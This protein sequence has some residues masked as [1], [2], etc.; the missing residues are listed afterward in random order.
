MDVNI[1]Y[2]GSGEVYTHFQDM[3]PSTSIG[4]LKTQ[5]FQ[6]F[7]VPPRMQDP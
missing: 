4:E 6:L 3:S 1:L 2:L 7:H 5:I